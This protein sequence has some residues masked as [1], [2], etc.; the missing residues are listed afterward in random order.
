MIGFIGGCGW[1]GGVVERRVDACRGR[2]VS[3]DGGRCSRK[4]SVAKVVMEEKKGGGL[5]GGFPGLGGGDGEKKEGGGGGMFG[6]MG[7]VMEAMKKAQEFT[8]ATKKLQEDLKESEVTAESECGQVTAVVSGQQVPLSVTISDEVIAKGAEA[9][10][11]AVT[12]AV[13][14]AHEK[15]LTD[16]REQ[17]SALSAQYGLPTGP[18]PS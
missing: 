17:L 1:S 11:A 12:D 15:S 14:K 6:G 9:T 8:E 3:G 7:N 4:R 18:P 16:M 10:S 2:V 5:F 13:K